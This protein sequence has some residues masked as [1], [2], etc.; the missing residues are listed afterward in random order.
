[1]DPLSRQGHGPLSIPPE[2]TQLTWTEPVRHCHAWTPFLP[3]P[4]G[5]LGGA[6]ELPPE[7]SGSTYYLCVLGSAGSFPPACFPAS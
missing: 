1:M 3:P 4:L 5:L 2:L 7:T 6:T